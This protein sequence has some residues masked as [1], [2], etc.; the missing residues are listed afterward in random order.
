MRLRRACVSLARA[1]GA[2]GAL[3][4]LVAIAAGLG[5]FDRSETQPSSAPEPCPGSCLMAPGWWDADAEPHADRVAESVVHI[6]LRSGRY[7][8]QRGS[9]FIVEVDETGAVWVMTAYH[10]VS[11]PTIDEFESEVQQMGVALASPAEVQVTVDAGGDVQEHTARVEAYNEALDTALLSICCPAGAFHPIT[12]SLPMPPEGERLPAFSIGFGK[13]G[14]KARVVSGKVRMGS[15]GAQD[16]WFDAGG[17]PGDSGS[18]IFLSETGEVVW[19]LLGRV[20]G[21][22]GDIK[23]GT[24]SG[25]HWASF[26]LIIPGAQH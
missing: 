24:G 14:D 9:G 5:V 12:Y 26:G 11:Q 13:L 20:K 3:L 2:I 23:D 10:A 18:P 17:V 6:G 1:A 4:L 21:T 7:S 16:I 8:A 19:M 15:P 25:I 22:V